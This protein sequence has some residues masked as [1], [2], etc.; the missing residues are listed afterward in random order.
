MFNK[1]VTILMLSTALIILGVV[2]F[3]QLPVEMKTSKE[4]PKITVS[5]SAN[6]YSPEMLERQITQKVE[7]SISVLIVSLI[8]C[9][10]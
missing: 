10:K 9:L 8:F 1:P 2:F 7:A 5:I 4:F 3:L 6:G